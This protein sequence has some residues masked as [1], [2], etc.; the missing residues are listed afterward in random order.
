MADSV[1]EFEQV[2]QEGSVVVINDTATTGGASYP[3]VA[4]SVIDRFS[5][6]NLSNNRDIQWSLDGGTT[7]VTVP[8]ESTWSDQ[9]LKGNETQVFIQSV[10]STADFELILEL[11]GY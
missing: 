9:K 10:S 7:V 4:G 5:I 11:E 3:S 2:N 1:P 6:T 8:A